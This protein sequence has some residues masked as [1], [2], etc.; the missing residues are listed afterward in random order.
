VSAGALEPEVL[1]VLEASTS[2]VVSDALD[3]MGDREQVLDPAIRALWPHARLTGVA[4]PV[5]IVA[6]AAEPDLPYDG[7]LTALDG[8]RPGDVPVFVVEPGV[9]AASWGELFTCA[10]MGRGAAG[11]VADGLVRD[12][13]QIEALGFPVFARGLSP[14]DTFGRAVVSGI[15][16]EARVGGVD[17]APGDVIV[18]DVDGVVVIP[19]ALAADVA[20]AVTTKQQ[21]EGDA[22]ND[23]LAGM[24]LREVWEK[25]GVL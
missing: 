13:A 22:R 2:A 16:V 23:L 24:S 9:R 11:L 3:R 20:E 25:Y 17:V 8:L 15:G 12:A 10:A 4:V 21:L 19:R 6:E 18:G 5:V 7:E 14:L 1:A